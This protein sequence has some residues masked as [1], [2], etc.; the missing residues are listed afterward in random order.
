MQ[1][2]YAVNNQRQGPV[3]QADFD[4]LVADGIIKPDT[5]VWQQGMTDWKPYSTIAA[6]QPPVAGIGDDTAVCAVSGKRFP[7][8]E[9]IQYEGKWI[10]AEHR[11]AFFQRM[12]EGVADPS[13]GIVPGPFGYGGFWRRV[14]AKLVDG[15]ILMVVNLFIGVILG[16]MFG[17][18]G[19]LQA[20]A[21]QG[22]V[23]LQ[24]ILQVIYLAIGI[25]YE[26]FFM[27][28]FDATPG[29]L[30]LGMKVL[31]PDGAKL[32]IGRI[33][34]RYFAHIIDGLTLCIGY[35]MA[36]FD[37]EKRTLHDRICDTRVIKT[38]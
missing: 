29:K 1:W 8:R 7:K 27:R 23:I 15:I 25:S 11:D 18:T 5:L 38:K 2:Y 13:A 32:S 3:A 17:A 19:Q 36:G 35:I 21:M 26:I 31:R 10:S 33:I 6:T 30:A 24:V 16:G 9:M 20:G 22:F 34:G 4:K 37:E 12:R 14:V 28:K